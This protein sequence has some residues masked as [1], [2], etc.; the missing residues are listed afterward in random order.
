MY[1]C[2][3]CIRFSFPLASVHAGSFNLHVR[4]ANQAVVCAPARPSVLSAVS[5][6]SRAL[7]NFQKAGHDRLPSASLRAVQQP[8]WS[9]S[10]IS[11]L[12]KVALHDVMLRSEG[13]MV[14][15][16]GTAGYLLLTSL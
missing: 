15:G 12:S 7:T 5:R 3:V 6:Q 16:D 2:S 8:T 13:I 4:A 11:S 14:P 1:R 9:W 10:V